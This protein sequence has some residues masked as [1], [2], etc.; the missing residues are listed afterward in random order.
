MKKVL[1]LSV[2]AMCMMVSVASAKSVECK[3]AAIRSNNIVSAVLI[4]CD[5]DVPMVKGDTINVKV[6]NP[7]IKQIN[8]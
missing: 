2:L 4:N 5:S 6:V 8:D 1:M 3:V 7:T